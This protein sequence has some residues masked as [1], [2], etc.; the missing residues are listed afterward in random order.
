[1]GGG[2]IAADRQGLARAAAVTRLADLILALHA[3]YVGFVVGGL[4][5]IW[6]GIWRRWRWVRHFWFRLLHLAAIALVALEAFAGIACPLTV[7]ESWLRWEQ[8]PAQ[9]FVARWVHAILFW[10]LPAWAFTLLYIAFALVTL[11]TWQR[12]PPSR[13]AGATTAQRPG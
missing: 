7:L 4:G 1:M 9:G 12:W 5:L 10:D 11:L 6:L 13:P 3:A 2:A 8:E